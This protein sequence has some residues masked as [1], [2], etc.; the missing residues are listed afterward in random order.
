[1]PEGPGGWGKGLRV[2]GGTAFG[3]APWLMSLSVIAHD[4]GD[5]EPA[6]PQAPIDVGRAG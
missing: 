6:T 1:M 3:G 5:V 4:Q 2:E